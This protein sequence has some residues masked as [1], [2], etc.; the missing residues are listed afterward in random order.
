MPDENKNIGISTEAETGALV[1]TVY[2]TRTM[3][4]YA[5]PENEL[6][7][8]SLLNTLSMAFFSAS[9]GF[10][11][12]AIGL[13]INAAFQSTLTPAGKILSIVG[14]PIAVILSIIFGGLGIW[15]W[16]TRKSGL[17]TV[18]KESSSPDQG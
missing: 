3:K 14:A 18:E 7:S 11:S 1:R 16:K 4:V 6:R 8:L 12:F 15:A 17:E 9:S 10:L 5:I 2:A 13:W